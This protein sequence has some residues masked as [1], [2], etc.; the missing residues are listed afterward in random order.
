MY[1]SA[2]TSFPSFVLQTTSGADLSG[3][4]CSEDR[5]GEEGRPGGHL[6]ACFSSASCLHAGLCQN[7]SSAQVGRLEWGIAPQ[8]GPGVE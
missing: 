5:G 4:E 6:Y 7:R 3:G 1:P 2:D 8:I